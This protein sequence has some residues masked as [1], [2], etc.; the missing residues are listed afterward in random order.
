MSEPFL[1]LSAADRADALGVAADASGRPAHLLEKDVWIVWVLEA[2]FGEHLGEHLSFKGGT[3]LS[4]AYRVI[5]RFSEDIDVTYDIRAL[6]PDAAGDADEPLPATRSQEKRWSDLVRQRL[7]VWVAEEVLPV[8]EARLSASGAPAEAR[9]EIDRL[10]V[11]YEPAVAPATGYV[12]PEVLIEFGARSTGEPLKRMP[13][14]CDAA[15]HLPMVAFPTATPRV[16]AAERTFWEKATAAHVFCLQGRLRGERYARH[17]YDLV[18]LD[19]AGIAA[20][21]LADRELAR[22]VARHKQW[23]FAAKDL[24]GKVISHDAAVDGALRLVPSGQ[25][26]DVLA[27]DYARMVEAGL[28][29]ESAPS[30]RGAR[31]GRGTSPRPAPA[32]RAGP[33]SSKRHTAPAP[34]PASS[35]RPSS[36]P[37]RSCP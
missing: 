31:R 16:M 13:V 32:G 17:W 18:R 22:A 20:A 26:F 29:E 8:V 34:H 7:P 1:R 2:L 37:S 27:E 23:F 5:G 36:R 35:R 24:E 3:S 33:R 11:C 30:R 25:P 6:L 14:T 9:A 4:K 10:Y 28:L 21:A 15:P 12:A 19:D